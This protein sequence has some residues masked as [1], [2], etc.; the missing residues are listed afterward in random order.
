M[1][2]GLM[3]K[4][5]DPVVGRWGIQLARRGWT[6]DKMTLLGLGLGLG[7]AWIIAAGLPGA[8]ALLPLLAGRMADGLDGAIARAT[9]K[10]DFGGFLDIVADFLFYGAVPLAFALRLPEA[11][12]IPACFLLLTF[13]VNGASFLAYAVLAE[14]HDMHTTARGEKSLYFTSGLLE[15]TETILFFVAFCLW[16]GDF[17]PMAWIFGLLCLCTI[18]ARVMLARRVFGT[19]R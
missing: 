7:S 18:A 1:L 9:Q 16:P 6:A 5:I 8:L 11:N 13:Y 12:A 14:K 15:G 17:A 2:D 3:R 4:L 19:G 10:S